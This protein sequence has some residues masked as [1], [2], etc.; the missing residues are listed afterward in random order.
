MTQWH[1]GPPPSMGW[2]LIKFKDLFSS[3]Y[4]CWWNGEYWSMLA[5]S[6]DSAALA[7]MRASERGLYGTDVIKWSARPDSWP[8]RSRT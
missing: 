7:A 4:L 5:N 6:R 2:W 3:G 8:A 1:S